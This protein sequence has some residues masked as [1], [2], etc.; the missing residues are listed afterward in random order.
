MRA[1]LAIISSGTKVEIREIELKCKP[2]QFLAVSPTS[3]VPCLVTD[4][5][6][7]DESLDIM[8]WALRLNDPGNCLE[9]P[10]LAFKL[11]TEADGPFKIAL[12]KTKYSNRF[13]NEDFETNRRLACHFLYKLNDMLTDKY[14]FGQTLT[15]AD[16]AILPFIRQFANIDMAWFKN[17]AWGKLI[18]WLD[19]FL[20]SNQF[21]LIM[22]KYPVW[23]HKKSSPIL[24]NH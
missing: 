6:N 3:S 24:L 22:Q 9:M 4:H 23:Q 10:D 21:N 16:M 11:I 7:I 18:R 14:L 5:I 17:Q 15:L 8:L 19:E 20:N 1:R 2:A 12:D 13:P